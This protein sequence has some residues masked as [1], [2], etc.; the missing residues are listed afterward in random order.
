MSLDKKKQDKMKRISVSGTKEDMKALAEV[1]A[2]TKKMFNIDIDVK[3]QDLPTRIS[4]R[5]EVEPEA[6]TYPRV[7]RAL[8][9]LDVAFKKEVP[10]GE[11]SHTV[12]VKIGSMDWMYTDPS[13][14][15]PE[16]VS[17]R[18]LQSITEGVSRPGL[19]A[20]TPHKHYSSRDIKQGLDDMIEGKKPDNMRDKDG[21]FRTLQ[22]EWVYIQ[23]AE[24]HPKKDKVVKNKKELQ[25]I[26]KIRKLEEERLDKKKNAA[27][28]PNLG[29][30]PNSKGKKVE[31][32]Q[33]TVAVFRADVEYNMHQKVNISA[34]AWSGLMKQ[35]PDGLLSKELTASKPKT[36]G[37]LLKFFFAYNVATFMRMENATVRPISP[38]RTAITTDHMYGDE[39]ESKPGQISQGP[40]RKLE[41]KIL[42]SALVVGT[43]KYRPGFHDVAHLK[44]T[45]IPGWS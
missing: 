44:E 12:P 20:I 21:L 11:D 31:P 32:T 40:L 38:N 17:S 26:R 9:L 15:T 10:R 42:Y 45:E 13:I 28:P 2:Q 19:K 37:E 22:P 39:R 23:T 36:V 34:S 18:V 1:L 5:E 33:A 27:Y 30:I 14:A 7:A 4:L 41:D 25:D 16:N 3:Q 6:I 8:D 24:V 43:G 35:L 29:M